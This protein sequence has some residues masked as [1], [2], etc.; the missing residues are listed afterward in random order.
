MTVPNTPCTVGD[1]S[2]LKVLRGARFPSTTGVASARAW[3]AVQ[4]GNI[5]VLYRDNGKENGNY[6][7]GLYYRV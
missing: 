3:L 6:H 7:T 2:I 5:R 4:M 1:C